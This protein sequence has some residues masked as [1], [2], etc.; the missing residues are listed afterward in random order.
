MQPSWQELCSDGEGCLHQ[1]HLEMLNTSSSNK[2]QKQF[3]KFQYRLF[4]INMLIFF[5]YQVKF[6]NSRKLCT[7][8]QYTGKKQML[9]WTILM[10]RF[11][12][13]LCL[14]KRV[15]VSLFPLQNMFADT[16]MIKALISEYIAQQQICH[17]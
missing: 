6:T 4:C 1:E 16:L 11:L 14:Q 12:F 5:K 8:N 7:R 9:P 15:K 3:L 2:Q 10:R 13:F 17:F